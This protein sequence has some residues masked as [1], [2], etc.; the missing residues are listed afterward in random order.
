M[1]TKKEEILAYMPE[2]LKPIIGKVFDL[3]IQIEELRFRAGRPLIVATPTGSYKIMPDG[4]LSKMIVGAYIVTQYDIRQIFRLITDNSIY[5]NINDIKQGFITL[6]G[7][8]RVGIAGKGVFSDG[9]IVNLKDISSLNFRIA[10]QQI[11]AANEIIHDIVKNHHIISTL[12]VSPP[13][14]GKTTVIRDLARQISDIGYKVALVD[15]RNEIS[16]TAC[17]IAQNDVGTN[18]DIFVNVPRAEGIIM[19]ISFMS[20]DVIMADEISTLEDVD[21]MLNGFGSGV[22]FIATA[23]AQNASEARGRSVLIPLFGADKIEQI[24]SLKRDQNGEINYSVDQA[25]EEKCFGVK[26]V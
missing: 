17:G 25:Y 23:H 15:T 20:P 1:G 16:A 7:G 21:A 4:S 10:S 3:K 26:Q 12:I 5:C 2:N 24:I 22:K 14:V 13:G 6:A 11:G 8:D 18:T 9:K 19:S